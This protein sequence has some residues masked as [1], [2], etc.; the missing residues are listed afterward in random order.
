MMLWTAPPGAVHR[1]CASAVKGNVSQDKAVG[2]HISE[3]CAAFTLALEMGAVL[4]D[5][6]E[7]IHA[8]PTLREAFHEAA[9]CDLGH[10]L[11]I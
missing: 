3:L 11:H 10:S 5:I 1:L 7:T 9:L 6:A 8:Q 2:A 4:E